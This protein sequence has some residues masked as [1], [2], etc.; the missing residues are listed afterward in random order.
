AVTLVP[1]EEP[2]SLIDEPLCLENSVDDEYDNTVTPVNESVE[3]TEDSAE[4]EP[5]VVT[6]LKVIDDREESGMGMIVAINTVNNPD[7]TNSA[8]PEPSVPS[9]LDFGQLMEEA[10]RRKT[11]GDLQGTLEIFQ[12]ITCSGISMEDEIFIILEMC[13]IYELMERPDEAYHQITTYWG[14]Y[15]GNLP[16]PILAEIENYLKT[17]R[18]PRMADERNGI[19]RTAV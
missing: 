15:Q 1:S 11:H 3:T 13:A 8:P 10:F 4:P 12:Q 9:K 19:R 17:Y 18:A 14:K 6:A 5:K 2:L 7:L 16:A